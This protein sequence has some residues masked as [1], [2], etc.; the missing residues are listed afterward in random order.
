MMVTIHV[1][2][3]QDMQDLLIQW[4]GKEMDPKLAAN[5][6]LRTLWNEYFV[7]PCGAV[8]GHWLAP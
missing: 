5:P 2:Q 7:P 8:L 3:S 1:S 4:A 6:K